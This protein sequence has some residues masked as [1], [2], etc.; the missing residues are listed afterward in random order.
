[1]QLGVY[2]QTSHW[3]DY[4]LCD[5]SRESLLAARLSEPP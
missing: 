1:M 5:G 3:T 2:K 4:V